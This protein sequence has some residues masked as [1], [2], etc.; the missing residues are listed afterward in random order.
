MELENAIKQIDPTG[1]IL[2][3]DTL[4]LLLRDFQQHHHTTVTPVSIQT[5]T[6]NEDLT[7]VNPSYFTK[8]FTKW[9]GVPSTQRSPA[10]PRHI[11]LWSF[12]GSFI[13]ILCLMT[14][15]TSLSDSDFVAIVGSFGAHAVLVFAAPHANLAQPWNAIVGN[16]VSAF[17]GVTCF[18]IFGLAI[19]EEG[20]TTLLGLNG[21]NWLAAPLAVSFAITLQ[22][23]TSSLHPP[24]GAIALIACIAGP[25]IKRTGYWYMIFPGL[26]GSLI[27]VFLAIIINNLSADDKRRYPRD[28]SPAFFCPKKY[29]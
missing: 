23:F 27:Q 19:P 28:W 13:G 8:Y 1:G 29:T 12:I 9:R 16:V 5:T 6:A 10:T 25:G 7:D 17:V 24:G 20:V 3:K 22:F 2:N 14:F 21:M 11:I 15:H 4:A 26:L 18:K